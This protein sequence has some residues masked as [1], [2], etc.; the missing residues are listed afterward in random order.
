MKTGIAFL[1][2]VHALTVSAAANPL[3]FPE[4]V[5]T[6]TATFA[7]PA[8]AAAAEMSIARLPGGAARAFGTR[9]DDTNPAHMAKA[10]M[11]ERAGVKGAFYIGATG[12]GRAG[13]EFRK[14]GIRE[15]I[16]RGHAIGNHTL[17][18]P[19]MLDISMESVFEQ[20]LLNR[21]LLERDTD[22]S[23][24]SYASPYG[25][26]QGRWLS[27]AVQGLA[28]KIL[29]ESGLWVSGDNPI[30]SID[31]PEDVWYPAHRFSA[32]DHN[33]DYAKFTAGLKAQTAIADGSPLSPRITLGT[34]SWCDA[35]GNARQEEWLKKHCVRPDWVQLN[36]YEYGAYLYSSLNGSASR[37]TVNGSKACFRVR[38]FSPS[39][40]GDAIALSVQF[41]KA[42]VAVECGGRALE[43]GANGTWTLPHD[44]GQRTVDRV[45]LVDADG[46]CE[47][48]PGVEMKVVPDRASGKVKVSF[49]NK[50]GEELGDLYGVAHLPPE[51]KDRRRTFRV[52]RVAAGETAVREFDLGAPEPMAY[53]S[54]K[55][56]Y[57]ASVDFT[58]GGSRMRIWA[59]AECEPKAGVLL[60]R[61]AVRIT[62]PVEAARLDDARLQ[63]ISG[64]RGPLGAAGD[65]V[66]WKTGPRKQSD[67]W[68]VVTEHSHR[69]RPDEIAAIGKEKRG[70]EAIVLQFTARE[71]TETTLFTNAKRRDANAG[72]FLNGSLLPLSGM[73]TVIPARPGLNRLV[74]R[75]KVTAA[76]YT[77]ALQVAVCENG[78]F[79]TPCACVPFETA[80]LAAIP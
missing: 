79:S 21:I 75:V 62:G 47:K 61:D 12:S 52:E 22:H 13:V 60:P 33:P 29:T 48:I 43:R 51:F 69:M 2:C 14:N 71:G 55:A 64:A 4:Y 18:H 23:V 6:V 44:A 41:S 63:A 54:G 46:R 1:A 50:T 8:D 5:Q 78:M 74:V 38:R 9:W 80:G 67:A 57:A 37:T 76:K 19:F 70:A 32:D 72:V 58:K 25:W 26:Y 49:A 30:P 35:A 16:A 27:P 10:A 77:T 11:L 34:H 65:G 15:L 24:V 45:G 68:Y 73:K 28:V 36:D 56:M 53:P 66:E 31:V 17:S 42:P 40:L 39:A 20:M 7:S 59:R 3:G